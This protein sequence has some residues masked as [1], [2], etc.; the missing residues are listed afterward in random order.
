MRDTDSIKDLDR[1]C[2]NSR[3]HMDRLNKAHYG[4][5]VGQLLHTVEHL[6]E[7]AARVLGEEERND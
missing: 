4:V 3:L 5:E 6:A 1:Q 7:V 2:E